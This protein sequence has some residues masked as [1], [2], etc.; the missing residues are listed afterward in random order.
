MASD[1]YEWDPT[2]AA[3]NFRKHGVRFSDAAT[4]LGDPMCVTIAD[5]DTNGGSA[6][7]VISSRRA[8]A[9]ERRRYQ[10]R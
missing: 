4:A 8:T 1:G 2:K 6:V 10:E 3:A 9:F 7:R 5:P